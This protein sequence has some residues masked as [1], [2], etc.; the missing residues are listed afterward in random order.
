MEII[1][2]VIVAIVALAVGYVCVLLFGK[3]KA[4]R[5]RERARTDVAS[6]TKEHGIDL[7]ARRKTYEDV[8]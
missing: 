3:R 7:Q 1:F 5:R 2:W 6:D 4:A 8:T